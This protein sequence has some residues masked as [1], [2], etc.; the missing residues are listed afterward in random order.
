MA[1]K[2]YALINSL[3]ELQRYVDRLIADGK[4]FGFDIETGYH[5][6]PVKK[7]ALRIETNFLVG[8]SF[9]NSLDWARYV[10]VAHDMAENLPIA[11]VLRILRPLLM[12]GLGVAHNAPFELR[13]LARAYRDNFPDDPE[14][15]ESR[16]YYPVRSC[17]QVEAYVK[18]DYTGTALGLK[19]LTFAVFGHKMTEIDEL[20]PNL[21]GSQK[22]TLRFNELP[23]TQ[24]VIDYACE[25]SLWSLANHY[26]T[27]PEVKDNFIYKLDMQICY[28]ISGM[29]D[30]GIQF[31][32]EM[33]RDAYARALDFRE[34][35][36]KEIQEDLSELLGIEVNAN[37]GS[38]AQLQKI[39]YEELGLKTTVMTK[40][41]KSG[42][43]K[44][45]TNDRA[46]EGLAKKNPVVARIQEWRGIQ[47]LITSYLATYEKQF[48]TAPD[49]RVHSS[50]NASFVVTGR[51][52]TAS[53]NYQ[54]L[55][56]IY[57]YD[58]R[59]AAAVHEKHAEA[60]GKKCECND[61]E[62]IP[63]EGTCFKLNFRDV[64]IV[65]EDY[66]FLGYD[67]SQAELRAIAGEAKEQ[68]LLSAF[69]RGDDVHR[70][71]AS[72]MLGKPEEEVVDKERQ[73]YGKRP[74]FSLLYGQGEK[75]F[76]E[77]LGV[78]QEEGVRLYRKYF[79]S[80]SAIAAY[81]DK[82]ERFGR[83][84]CFVWSKFGR[85]I[86]IENYKDPQQRRWILEAGDR[87][88]LNYPIQGCLPSDT[89][90]LTRDGWAPI[91]EFVDGSEVWTGAEWAEAIRLPK[92]VAPRLRLTLSDGR[93]FDCDDR[94]KLLVENGAWP[95]WCHVNDIAGRHLIR[96]SGTD[97]GLPA[98]E[99]E[100]WYWVGRFL[101]DGSLHQTQGN[102]K[103]PFLRWNLCFDRIK[104]AADAD[105]FESWLKTNQ[106]IFGSNRSEFGYQRYVDRGVVKFVGVTK[107][108]VQFWLD[109]G[110]KPGKLLHNP[111]V[112]S[113][114]F[115]LDYSR[116][117]AFYDGWF[118]ADGHA[119]NRARK[120]TT[121]YFPLA[122]DC[123]RLLQ[124]L[125]RTGSIGQAQSGG[126]SN[127]YDVYEHQENRPLT[128]ESVEELPAEEMFT[129]SVN[130]PRH[131]F[132]S[133]GLISK[134]SATGDFV[135]I[136]MVRAA[137]KIREAGLQDKIIL[138]MNV[139]DSLDF[140]VHK[141]LSPKFVIDLLKD[142][143]IFPVPGW[144]PMIAD[145]RIGKRWGSPK[146]L[147]L[148]DDGRIQ[149]KGGPFISE[150]DTE[151]KCSRTETVYCHV[152]NCH[153]GA[154]VVEELSVIEE[155]PEDIQQAV[156]P[157]Y[158]SESKRLI[159]E[160]KE[161][162]DSNQLS[163]F[164]TLLKANP[165]DNVVELRTPEGD[166]ELARTTA[167][168]VKDQTRISLALG[169]AR[170]YH[171]VEDVDASEVF[172]GLTL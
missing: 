92:G 32:W 76:G 111:H 93:Q 31:D 120:L 4:P 48:G 136:G 128:V 25:D 74:N 153:G 119:K 15:Q 69:E 138:V 97:W 67:L 16:G 80:F 83:K 38:S 42:V 55:P 44:M 118:D 102:N 88:A 36:N 154:D 164:V 79:E 105:T 77:M 159:I 166:K 146:D 37:L 139:H 101:G 13:C 96:D 53:P 71:T 151:C 89:R 130:H 160:L 75:A 49:G 110:I 114:V 113:Q 125:G 1:L 161:M 27:Y 167:L 43:K 156:T 12:T 116:R 87:N 115:S 50:H 158:E 172:A 9:T 72:L 63:A 142:E 60:H 82:Q 30:F 124:T 85:K 99:V 26:K 23:L 104:E 84:H 54:Q 33:L 135:R 112:P 28:V 137:K 52:S 152:D 147:I 21:Q 78:S 131:A 5:G 6:L 86:P 155:T 91:G 149:I 68:S 121:A 100:D 162:P 169:G 108:G 3:E 163:K 132:S 39:L 109:H 34:M 148:H 41:G 35:L 51:F 7:G 65:P 64:V 165:G 144:P 117:K 134:N 22:Q 129:L 126:G 171:P 103:T 133:E 98:G 122:Q 18:A 145:W 11:E 94:H 90:V 95:E 20:F 56:K 107:G 62:F 2:N 47:K 17:T 66:Y 123:L 14:I 73:V 29:E 57:H 140:Y 143:V 46:L 19:P 157:S 8:I 59:E 141:S 106:D 61:P 58:L 10:S 170:V 168:T 40:G 81:K 24:Q 127:W 150:A 45:S 70:L